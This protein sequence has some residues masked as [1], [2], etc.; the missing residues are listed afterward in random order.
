MKLFHISEQAGIPCFPPRPAD[1]QTAW[2][3]L[4]KEYVWAISDEM[5][6]NYFFPRNCPRVCWMIGPET[7]E[8]EKDRFRAHGAYRAIICV[9]SHWQDPIAACVLY[10]YEFDPLHFCPVDY[11]A[12]YYVSEYPET[13]VRVT[14]LSAIFNLLEERHVLLEFVEN[15]E[16]YRKRIAGSNYR[17][18][19]IRMKYLKRFP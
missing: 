6:H 13:P 2:P 17:F 19:N 12:G 4:D 7:T 11:C 18:S 9:E 1:K 16:P 15:L 3:N 14:K 5:I 8:E 10:Q